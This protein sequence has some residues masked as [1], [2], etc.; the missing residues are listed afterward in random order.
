[1]FSRGKVAARKRGKDK[2]STNSKGHR[3]N[4][5]DALQQGSA[6]TPHS[7][8]YYLSSHTFVTIKVINKPHTQGGDAQ[9][10]LWYSVL[11]ILDNV[12]TLALFM[13]HL[14]E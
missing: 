9:Y 2:I 11:L 13:L 5:Q 3:K 14:A 10:W 1:M 6:I 8:Q 7:E 12:C 4:I